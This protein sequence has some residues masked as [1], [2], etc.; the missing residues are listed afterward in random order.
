[1]KAKLILLFFNQIE[2]NIQVWKFYLFSQN[3]YLIEG[4]R[5]Y[6]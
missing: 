3:L 1:M 6:I 2:F 5:G 4:T